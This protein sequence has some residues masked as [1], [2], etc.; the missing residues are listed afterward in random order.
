MTA[1]VCEISAIWFTPNWSLSLHAEFPHFHLGQCPIYVDEEHKD[2]SCDCMTFSKESLFGRSIT[3]FST[4][5]WSRHT[6]S[7]QFALDDHLPQS[8]LSVVLSPQR[9]SAVV[10]MQTSSPCV[11]RRRAIG[12]RRAQ[13][14]RSTGQHRAR[15]GC[16]L[17]LCGVVCKLETTLPFDG[18]YP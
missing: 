7:E 2:Q 13:R 11:Y 14:P 5:C 15:D 3:N 16:L 1:S 9:R 12:R 17:A 6:P 10:R 4:E 8:K 18:I